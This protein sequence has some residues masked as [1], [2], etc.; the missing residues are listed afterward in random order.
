MIG[1]LPRLTRRPSQTFLAWEPEPPEPDR[2][3]CSGGIHIA[4]YGTRTCVY[5]A[6]PIRGAR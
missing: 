3:V 6:A 5:C 2:T 4:A 1:L